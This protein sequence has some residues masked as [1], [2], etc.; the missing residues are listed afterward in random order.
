[1]RYDNQ[2]PAYRPTW[3]ET[4]IFWGAGATRALN[5][6]TTAE[7]GRAIYKLACLQQP[8]SERVAEAFGLT[9]FQSAVADLLTLLDDES[10][11]ISSAARQFSALDKRQQERRCNELRLSYDWATLR[12]LVHTCP[13]H[14]EAAFK[15]QDLFNLLD[16]HIESRH[17]FY[18]S[19]GRDKLFVHPESLVPARN[20]L[21][22]L[23][24]LLHF[25]DYHL[26]LETGRLMLEKYIG[27]AEF[28]ARLMQSEGLLLAKAG[29]SLDDRK[30][31][32]FSFA[33][34]SMNWDPLLLWLLF[35]AHKKVNHHGPISA[36]DETGAPLKLFHDFSHFM[37]VRRVDAA[38]PKLWY[39][40]NESVV[41]RMNDK[42]H[43]TSRRVRVGKFYFPHGCSGWRE[44][45][46]CGKLTMYLGDNWEYASVSLFPP[47]LL[48]ILSEQWRQPRSSEEAAAHKLGLVDAIQCA[49]CGALTELKNTPMLMQSNFKGPNP[50]F[51]EE[52][53]RDMRIAL[54]NAEHI[55]LLGYTLPPDDVI[56]R[57]LLAARQKR[58]T[59][60]P[61]CC[62][63]VVGVDDAAP[64]CWLSG[65]E[66]DAYLESGANLPLSRAVQAAR[67]IFPAGQVRGYGRGIPTVFTGC[68]GQACEQK[69]LELLYPASR[70]P[71]H[72]V[73]R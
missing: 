14:D 35:N 56:Y 53:Q 41:Q 58:T 2:L 67:E 21:V 63:V 64:D 52:I 46:N 66:L 12:R 55:V 5:M 70:F 11:V 54:E 29:H 38:G 49:Y 9:W 24:G 33:F 6:R 71:G 42:D 13:G 10:P 43:Y 8:L 61:P 4:V 28:L 45:P 69:I 3:P 17:G 39:P 59:G 19:G 23:I 50:P 44:C 51:V 26:T 27:F 36:V 73:E 60:S 48:P 47:P 37:G 62:S 15:L 18:V 34:I 31:Y 65:S 72:R 40:F 16:M 68:D 25:H 1:M 30:F 57:S 20:A 7:L 32:L 22:M